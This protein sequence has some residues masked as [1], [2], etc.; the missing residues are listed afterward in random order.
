MN[1]VKSVIVSENDKFSIP[2][3]L[4]LHEAGG[5]LHS[6][7]AYPAKDLLVDTPDAQHLA[8]LWEAYSQAK[9][10]LDSK[11]SELAATV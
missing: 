5:L 4:R 6:Q 2:Q 9:K 10:A 7:P 1:Q 8:S 11:I 3:I